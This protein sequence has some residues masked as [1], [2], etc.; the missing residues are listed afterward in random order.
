MESA[1][2]SAVPPQQLPDEILKSIGVCAL[3]DIGGMA[4]GT[5]MGTWFI[6]YNFFTGLFAFAAPWLPDYKKHNKNRK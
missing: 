5:R 3:R 6:P 1:Q 4:V 2:K